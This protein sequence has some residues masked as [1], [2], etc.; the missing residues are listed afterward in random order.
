[1][2][3]GIPAPPSW[4]ELLG[5]AQQDSL[6]RYESAV[7]AQ[8]MALTN[9]RQ[10]ASEMVDEQDQLSLSR[11]MRRLG[12]FMQLVAGAPKTPAELVMDLIRR[13]TKTNLYQTY[14]NLKADFPPDTLFGLVFC[15]PNYGRFKVL[16]NCAP[17]HPTA[18]FR[19]ELFVSGERLWIEEL[20]D[21]LVSLGL[22]ELP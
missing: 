4:D 22:P 9:T 13:P 8:I 15:W 14:Q 1:M 2:S 12:Y 10:L 6:G 5:S 16:H 18:R 17:Q 21:L 7:A 20:S 11:C 3:D 19:I